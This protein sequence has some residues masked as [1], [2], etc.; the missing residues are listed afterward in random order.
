L[1]FFK[2]KKPSAQGRAT[3]ALVVSVYLLFV[4]VLPLALSLVISYRALP[5]GPACP[6]CSGETLRLLRRTTEW[7]ARQLRRGPVQRRWCPVCGWEGFCKL[8]E[9]YT[10]LEHGAPRI[11]QPGG[12]TI[13]LRRLEVDGRPWR[14]LMRC[15]C[16]SERWYGQLFFSAASGRLLE[17]SNGPLSGA[18][19]DEILSQAQR[20]PDA[21]L[22]CR[23]RELAR[24]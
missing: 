5:E 21:S 1:P 22:T 2:V 9:G 13:E 16:D 23:V 24:D 6:S 10:G 4:V 11:E 15:W 12:A 14:V 18:S 19:P 8:P 3:V 17:D 20:L 7:F